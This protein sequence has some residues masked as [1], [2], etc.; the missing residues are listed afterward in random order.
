MTN[1]VVLVSR[2]GTVRRYALPVRLPV[3]I[4]Q[5]VMSGYL[6][7]GRLSWIA[8]HSGDD[9]I[10]YGYGLLNLATGSD[11]ASPFFPSTVGNYDY[12]SPQD[13]LFSLT[14]PITGQVSSVTVNQWSHGTLTPLGKI[15]PMLVIGIEKDGVVWGY[16]SVKS[17]TEG[18]GAWH[19]Y[20]RREVPG[21]GTV[22]SW[23]V[24]GDAIGG[25]PGYVAY[26]RRSDPHS[27]CIFF[28]LEHRT[29]RFRG[30]D[31]PLRLRT[32]IPHGV[33]VMGDNTGR[34]WYF[35]PAM[36]VVVVGHEAHTY[37]IEITR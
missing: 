12:L 15:A 36:S 24:P 31:E 1:T 16:A 29:L 20:V 9:S 30:L 3:P 27:L 10:V 37:E 18:Q 4:S 22:R 14:Y 2:N 6:F 7:N 23:I 25:G 34:Q 8:F 33:A 13:T 32:V 21:S 26:I 28:P 11:S 17:T 35:D 19:V 5:V